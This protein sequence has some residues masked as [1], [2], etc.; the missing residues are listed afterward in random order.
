MIVLNTSPCSVQVFA[1]Q[2]VE[3]FSKVFLS[4]LNFQLELASNTIPSK[5][6][7]HHRAHPWHFGSRPLPATAPFGTMPSYFDTLASARVERLRKEATDDSPLPI[8]VDP[9]SGLG[10]GL[11]VIHPPDAHYGTRRFGHPDDPLPRAPVAYG[12]ND[13][14]A[15]RPKGFRVDVGT[16]ATPTCHTRFYFGDAEQHRVETPLVPFQKAHFDVVSESDDLEYEGETKGPNWEKYDAYRAVEYDEIIVPPGAGRVRGFF[17]DAKFNHKKYDSDEE[18][19]NR[20]AGVGG[21]T[22]RVTNILSSAEYLKEALTIQENENK[23]IGR[24]SGSVPESTEASTSSSDQKENLLSK[25]SRGNTG[26]FVWTQLGSV[27]EGQG[28]FRFDTS[29]PDP[30]CEIH[31]QLKNWYVQIA[32]LRPRTKDDR[33]LLSK[34]QGAAIVHV[35]REFESE[36]FNQVMAREF[37]RR[38]DVLTGRL[39]ARDRDLE[40]VNQTLGSTSGEL[41]AMTDD[42]NQLEKQLA[43][44]SEE[45]TNANAEIEK[46]RKEVE[47]LQQELKGS[48]SE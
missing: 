48:D 15:N 8:H 35:L 45:L 36:E 18:R 24:I 11:D 26:G 13:S 47:R 22:T 16:Q 14:S 3:I 31:P 44:K 43:A 12:T 6:G 21:D 10:S 46:L 1:A 42:R 38:F 27:P 41:T 5:L 2:I 30:Y 33:A 4:T 19:E 23:G 34:L 20:L 9:K 37:D 29:K 17:G 40:S 32:G 28:A 25:T 7:S 39:E